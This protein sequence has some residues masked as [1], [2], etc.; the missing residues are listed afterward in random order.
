MQGVLALE[1]RVQE[2][3][4]NGFGHLS[5]MPWQRSQAWRRPA[6]A[7]AMGWAWGGAS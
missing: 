6:M 4:P 1:Q 7:G 5:F 3:D 2:S